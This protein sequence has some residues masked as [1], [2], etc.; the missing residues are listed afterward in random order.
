MLLATDGRLRREYFKKGEDA[1]TSLPRGACHQDTDAF[2]L[3]GHRLSSL[4]RAI[5]LARK[6]LTECSSGNVFALH[7]S[8]NTQ[9][10]TSGRIATEAFA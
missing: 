10:R 5:N 9:I 8:G 3:H 6:S 7:P 4:F 2:T 1:K